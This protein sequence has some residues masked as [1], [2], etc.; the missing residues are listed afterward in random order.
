MY[1]KRVFI[2]KQ[3]HGVTFPDSKVHGANMGPTWVLS[4]PGG[5]HVGPMNF[6]I[7]V[8]CYFSMNGTCRW[9]PIILSSSVISV[10][11]PDCFCVMIYCILADICHRHGVSQITIAC[12]C[13][14]RN[15]NWNNDV[16]LPLERFSKFVG[17]KIW[18][19]SLWYQN[20]W[21]FVSVI[22]SL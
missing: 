12:C 17:W 20:L 3:H 9:I 10:S 14:G 1:R 4:A 8:A 16:L 22:Q 19:H 21:W 15:W 5:P 7:R 2:V 13:G 6:A 18:W 11:T